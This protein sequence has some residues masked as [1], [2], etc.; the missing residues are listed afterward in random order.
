MGIDAPV[1]EWF[2][3]NRFPELWYTQLPCKWR[4]A[5]GTTSTWYYGTEN[6]TCIYA[7]KNHAAWYIV[8]CVICVESDAISEI[9]TG[10]RRERFWPL[11]KTQL[12]CGIVHNSTRG[13]RITVRA[14]KLDCT[15]HSGSVISAAEKTIET[16]V[17]L[18]LLLAFFW[19]M[20]FLLCFPLFWVIDHGQHG[21]WACKVRAFILCTWPLGGPRKYDYSVHAMSVVTDEDLTICAGNF[22]ET[23]YYFSRR[24][25]ISPKKKK[26]FTRHIGC[27]THI[28]S[29]K[30][31]RKY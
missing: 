4:K 20:A 8:V 15:L 17:K 29:I 22:T 31:R 1:R 16:K 11:F 13:S 30:C 12:L 25:L 7:K 26:K 9:W 19:R 21:S 3:S 23:S 5:K 2:R 6:A 10:F 27:L 24:C 18:S 28:Q 14:N